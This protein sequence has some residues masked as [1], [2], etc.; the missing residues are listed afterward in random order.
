[1]DWTKQALKSIWSVPTANWK[2][3]NGLAL[4]E[5]TG[6]VWLASNHAIVRKV[7]VD[8]YARSPLGQSM[9]PDLLS[10]L[11]DTHASNRMFGL[12]AIEEILGRQLDEKEYAPMAEPSKRER[13]VRSLTEELQSGH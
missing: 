8:A 12:M 1:M 10:I 3:A 6:K 4:N 9:L 2:P 7:T 5:P 11:N 13:Q